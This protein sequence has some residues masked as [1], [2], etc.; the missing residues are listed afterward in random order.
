[1]VLP[2]WNVACEVGER[3]DRRTRREDHDDGDE[4]KGREPEPDEHAVVAQVSSDRLRGVRRSSCLRGSAGAG[5]RHLC[6]A[7]VR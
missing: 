1:M 7:F 3:E 5:A 6:L 4:Q 2:E